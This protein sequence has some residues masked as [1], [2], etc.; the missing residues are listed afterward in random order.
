MEEGQK[1]KSFNSR[2]HLSFFIYHLG[3]SPLVM[4]KI[5]CYGRTELA[6]LYCP[7]ILPQSAFRKFMSWL[8]LN[9]R[10]RTLAKRRERTFT[11]AQVARIVKELGEP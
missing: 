9:P 2:H 10:L 6:Q 7:D 11:P 4:F 3:Q 5:R 1:P 8:R